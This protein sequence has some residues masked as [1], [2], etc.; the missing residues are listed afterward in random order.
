[1]DVGDSGYCAVMLCSNVQV[2]RPRTS[3]SGGQFW[4]GESAGGAVDVVVVVAVRVDLDLS[5]PIVAQDLQS[6]HVLHLCDC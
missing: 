4:F 1:V 2:E 6:V 5:L 3:T